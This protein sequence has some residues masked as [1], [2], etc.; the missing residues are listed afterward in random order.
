MAERERLVT[1]PLYRKLRDYAAELGYKDLIY[2]NIGEPDF[3]TPQN[4]IN[5]AVNA[6]DTGVTHYTEER[7]LLELRK[8]IATKLQEDK[9]LEIGSEGILITNGS[10]EA[11]FTILISLINPDDEVILFDPYY[12]SYLSATIMAHGKPIL[13]PLNKETL[14]PEPYSIESLITRKTKAL[15]VNS[16]CNPTGMVYREQT[17]KTLADIAKDHDLYI[18]SD[19]VYDRF[20]YDNEKC[21]SI[22]SYDKA[23]E[24]TII[25]NSFSKTY[26][27]TGWRVGYL[28][29]NKDITDGMLKLKSAINVCANSISQKAALAAL[30]KSEEYVQK[31]LEEYAKRRQYTLDLLSKI[32]GFKCPISKGAFYLFPDI[33]EIE[34]DS[35]KFSMYLI[36]EAHLVVSPGIAFGQRGEGHIRISYASSMENLIAAMERLYNAVEKYNIH[37][38]DKQ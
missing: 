33:S 20:L 6:M 5:A 13:S 29:T 12:P 34:I 35:L 24:R 1:R 28:A 18:L 27:M 17:L 14:M 7:G 22:A 2:L 25:V 19:E 9:N 4:I 26:A 21:P 23:L 37:K 30:N 38:E 31:M 16:P 15:I 11:I 32:K 36:K 10:A 8:A 3:S